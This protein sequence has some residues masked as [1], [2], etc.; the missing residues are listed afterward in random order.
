L[1]VRA[2]HP[3]LQFRFFPEKKAPTAAFVMRA[4]TLIHQDQV[5]RLEGFQAFRS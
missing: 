4:S 1:Q 2:L 5:G 3:H